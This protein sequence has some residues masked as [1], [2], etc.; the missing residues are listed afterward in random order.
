MSARGRP[1]RAPL[2]LCRST[3][4]AAV[5]RVRR[6]V[7]ARRREADEFY[8]ACSTSSTTMTPG[9]CSARRFAGMI[10]SKQFYHYDVP[11]WLEGDPLSR[12]RRPGA[13]VAATASGH[14]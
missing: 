14:I 8:G 11:R 4:P 10:W 9:K 13:A 1:V 6:N 3:P 12:R 7:E 2:R 5:R